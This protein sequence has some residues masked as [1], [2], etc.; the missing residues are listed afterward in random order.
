MSKL[1]HALDKDYVPA[2][3]TFVDVDEYAEK[4]LENAVVLIATLQLSDVGIT[5]IYVN[6]KENRNAYLSTIG[7]KRRVR[8]HGVGRA[9][10]QAAC[11]VAVSNGM[12]CVKLEVSKQNDAAI[13]FYEKMGFVVQETKGPKT[14]ANSVLMEKVF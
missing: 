5:A 11:D 10:M 13:G 7:A 4:L 9:L 6:D 1:L 3:S 2:L 12:Q 14:Y 8:H